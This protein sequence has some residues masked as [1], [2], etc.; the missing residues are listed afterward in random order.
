MKRFKYYYKVY[1]QIIHDRL[2]NIFGFEMRS[3]SRIPIKDSGWPYS[4]K[5]MQEIYKQ[6]F[7]NKEE[8]INAKS[9]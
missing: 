9:T 5:E 4:Y 7:K 2:A 6:F 3:G 1:R 8:N